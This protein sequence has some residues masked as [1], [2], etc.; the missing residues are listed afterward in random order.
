MKLHRWY[1]TNQDEHRYKAAAQLLVR[2]I[3][4]FPH[5]IFQRKPVMMENAS[6]PRRDDL[7]AMIRDDGFAEWADFYNDLSSNRRSDLAAMWTKLHYIREIGEGSDNIVLMSDNLYPLVSFD[8]IEQ[9]TDIVPDDIYGLN[10]EYRGWDEFPDCEVFDSFDKWT[11]YSGYVGTG[12]KF[13]FTPIGARAF[14]DIW[15]CHPQYAARE[16]LFRVYQSNP[17]PRDKWL[18]ISPSAISVAGL[19][20]GEDNILNIRDH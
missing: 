7:L 16:L 9:I 8:I 13:L 3:L 1:F 18:A 15:R 10:F 2:G 11:I 19:L 17:F 4:K 6:M 14:M 12:F 5:D 20:M